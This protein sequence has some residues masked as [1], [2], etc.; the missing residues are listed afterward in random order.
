M[1]A[2]GL[3]VDHLCCDIGDNRYQ[4]APTRLKMAVFVAAPCPQGVAVVQGHI[5][6]ARGL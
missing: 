2:G 6:E 5:H 3:V 4:T 1:A